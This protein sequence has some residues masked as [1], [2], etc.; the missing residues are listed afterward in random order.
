ME[1][2][3][4]CLKDEADV[5]CDLIYAIT[6]FFNWRFVFNMLLLMCRCAF[7]YDLQN[8]SRLCDFFLY[9]YI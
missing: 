1:M 2:S 7:K 5:V 9:I 6:P 4:F 8:K 3:V